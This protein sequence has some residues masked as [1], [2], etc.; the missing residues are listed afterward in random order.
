M[1]L[2]VSEDGT[3]VI[4]VDDCTHNRVKRVCPGQDVAADTLFIA[5][6]AILKMYSISPA[7]DVDGNEIQVEPDFTSGFISSVDIPSCDDPRD[8]L[9]LDT[10]IQNPLSVPSNHAQLPRKVYYWSAQL[11]KATKVIL[12]ALIQ[13]N[14]SVHRCR[15]ASR[16]GRFFGCF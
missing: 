10:A 4:P 13:T 1:L 2:S 11:N 15:L 6:A 9:L 7:K 14:R 3:P 16:Y 8:S 12:L 5:M